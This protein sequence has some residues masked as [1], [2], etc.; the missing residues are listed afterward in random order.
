MK[1]EKEKKENQIG[2]CSLSVK[3]YCSGNVFIWFSYLSW[4][5]PL[6]ALEIVGKKNASWQQMKPKLLIQNIFPGVRIN[7]KQIAPRG[8]QA[9]S[10][11]SVLKQPFVRAGFFI[12]NTDIIASL[13]RSFRQGRFLHKNW[14]ESRLYKE[15]KTVRVCVAAL[16]HIETYKTLPSRTF[17]HLNL[18]RPHYVDPE[19]SAQKLG[20][21]EVCSNK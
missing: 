7:Y 15:S 19:R 4:N 10:R 21:T 20:R 12:I 14:E 11:W 6:M 3:I 13:A 2:Q 18:P 17:H 1:K 8:F 5:S 16:H 9:L